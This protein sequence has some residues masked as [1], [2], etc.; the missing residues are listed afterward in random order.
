MIIHTD[1]ATVG[2]NGKLGTVSKVV[3]DDI[4]KKLI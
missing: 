2:H 1:G 3:F 4:I